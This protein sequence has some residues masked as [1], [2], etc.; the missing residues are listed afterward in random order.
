MKEV[1]STN[2]GPQ[3]TGAA[4]G[5]QKFVPPNFKATIGENI[6]SNFWLPLE[7]ILPP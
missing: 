3:L 6:S 5:K 1:M 7:E 4:P 2:A